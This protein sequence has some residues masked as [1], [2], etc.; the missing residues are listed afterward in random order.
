MVENS[1]S[2]SDS[3]KERKKRKHCMLLGFKEIGVML[4]GFE[5]D[6]FCNFTVLF[7]IRYFLVFG[8]FGKDQCT[9]DNLKRLSHS[10][11][12]NIIYSILIHIH[13]Q[14]VLKLFMHH[15]CKANIDIINPFVGVG[16][17]VENSISSSDSE[18]EN[19]DRKIRKHCM[20]LGFEGDCG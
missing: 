4:L 19:A 18:N 11:G 15:H 6:L 2:S 12:N 20:L 13:C 1:I 8:E 14:S 3:E 9:A 16:T 10:G 17:Q 5:G 7:E